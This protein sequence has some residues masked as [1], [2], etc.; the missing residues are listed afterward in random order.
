MFLTHMPQDRG[1]YLNT[2]KSHR[3]QTQEITGKHAF[4]YGVLISFQPMNIIAL[5]NPLWLFLQTLKQKSK[6]VQNGENL[7]CNRFVNFLTDLLL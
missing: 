6:Y 7:L 2:W 4:F 1:R 3:I 5:P